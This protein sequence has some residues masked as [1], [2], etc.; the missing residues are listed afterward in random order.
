MKI[1]NDN[2]SGIV[3]IKCPECDKWMRQTQDLCPDCQVF[4]IKVKEEE[5]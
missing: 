3:K 1:W 2:M 5:E 4:L